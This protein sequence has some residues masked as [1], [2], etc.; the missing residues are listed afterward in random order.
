[1]N[2]QQKPGFSYKVMAS[3]FSFLFSFAC[4]AATTFAWFIVGNEVGVP[5]LEFGI[6]GSDGMDI[7]VKINDVVNAE[8]YGVNVGDIY[9]PEDD[10][11]TEEIL[12]DLGYIGRQLLKPVS[13]AYQERWD[14]ISDSPQ[15][16][17]LPTFN[18]QAGNTVAS[19]GYYQIEFYFKVSENMHLY[20]DQTTTVV[21]DVIKNAA[22]AKNAEDLTNLNK[23]KDSLRV[24][25]YVNKQF[26]IYEPNVTESSNTPLFGKLDIIDSDGYYDF[27]Y[28][29]GDERK[30][31]LFGHYLNADKIV[32]GLPTTI[33]NQKAHFIN[34]FTAETYSG[35]IPVD[36]PASIEN[37]IE[38]MYQKTETLSKLSNK[39]D[40]NINSLGLLERGIDNR[41]VISIWSEGWDVDCVDAISR[42]NFI[43]NLVFGGNYIPII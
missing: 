15:F 24:G 39:T 4:L 17:R 23:V 27:E 38:G 13:S 7:G 18:D 36:V 34:C 9:Y 2:E 29:N 1:M 33:P 37:G 21:A 28:F 10:N 30:E 6:H 5:E 41:V 32:Y 11:V 14:G 43:A 12:T 3:L 22:I 40:D 16:T 8:K 20:L 26:T 19:N 25:M 31:I 42:S 35:V